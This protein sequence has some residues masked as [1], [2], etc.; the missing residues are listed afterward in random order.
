MT[1]GNTEINL[2]DTLCLR[3]TACPDEG[4]VVQKLN[5]ESIDQS[6]LK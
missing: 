6:N 5:K 2:S 4:R 1:Q 3:A